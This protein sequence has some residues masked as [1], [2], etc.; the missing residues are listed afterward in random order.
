MG[1]VEGRGGERRGDLEIGQRGR[2]GRR[3]GRESG[4]Q[5]KMT[6]GK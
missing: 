4:G 2:G 1:G 6:E 5:G 3:G